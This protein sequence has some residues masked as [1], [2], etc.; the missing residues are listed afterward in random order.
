VTSCSCYAPYGNPSHGPPE[1][2]VVASLGVGDTHGPGLMTTDLMLPAPIGAFRG[3]PL[4]MPGKVWPTVPG[5][6]R[7]E[8]GGLVL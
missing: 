7:K 5:T 1:A 2:A 8:I 6:S 4:G 3:G